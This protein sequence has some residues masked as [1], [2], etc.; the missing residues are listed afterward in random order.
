MHLF[1]RL[2]SM[3]ALALLVSALLVP[4]T[5]AQSPRPFEPDFAEFFD[6]RT[7]SVSPIAD[8][9][10]VPGQLI[11]RIRDNSRLWGAGDALATFAGRW[12]SYG[13][14]AAGSIAPGTY[15]LAVTGDDMEALARTMARDPEV[16]WAQ[17]NYLRSV[18][19]SV[20]DPLSTFQYAIDKIS[21]VGAWDITTGS[22]DIVIAIVNSG[23]SFD[24][25]EFA[26]R[27]V[28][29]YDFAND[30]ADPSDDNGHGTHVAGIAAAA[31]DNG[32][33]IAGMCWQCSIMPVKVI[34][35]SG[36][37]SDVEV[38]D[39]IRFAVDN[40]ARI[41]NLSLGG[42]RAAPL[43][44][45]AVRYAVDHNVLVV[46]A[47][48]N[49]YDEGNPIAFPAAYDEVLAV[50]ATDENDQHAP[51]SNVHP[52]VDIAAPGW[53]IAS[54]WADIAFPPVPYLV[55]PGT[56]MSSPYVAGLAGLLLSLNPNLDVN[57]L[58]NTITA[59]ADDVGEPGVDWSFGAG[60]INAQRAVAS[61]KSPAFEPAVNPNQPDVLWFGETQHTLRGTFR[62]FWEQNG[63]LRVFGFPITEEFSQTSPEGTFTV[64]Y[65][66]RNRFELHPEKQRPTTCCSAASAT[67]SLSSRAATGFSSPKAS[68]RRAAS[69][70]PKP[71]TRSVARF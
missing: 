64:Q 54:T 66:E 29:G 9:A 39:G 11:V 62:Q 31:G 44:R 65:F 7:P 45:E 23:I 2:A 14:S 60:R 35:R 32:E 30:D 52:Y 8:G 40:G 67:C 71:N 59:T 27:I 55:L 63:G 49:E 4:A 36:S 46:A 33:G 5:Y 68:R 20:N 61:V 69:S 57:A 18:T 16:L 70:S 24:H 19:R 28:P 12:S 41:I 26:G 15:R 17:P 22:S 3:S 13:I 53:N 47:A 56:S 21:A 43:L 42:S 25:P 38:A 51:F 1:R 34:G 37:G 6:Q 48:G 50:A 10:Y 58:R